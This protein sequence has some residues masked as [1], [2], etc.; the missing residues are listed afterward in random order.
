MARD[1]KNAQ[2]FKTAATPGGF[3]ADGKPQIV[4]SGR[5]NVGKSSVINRLVKRK[6]LA[7]SGSSPGKTTNVNYYLIDDRAYFV[8]LPGYGYARAPGFER[9]RWGALM[10]E[11]F[12][13][14]ER[15][16][17]GVMLVDMRHSPTADD[18]TM[19]EWF[20]RSGRPFVVVANKSDKLKPAQYD[21]RL[22]DIRGVLEL[23]SDTRVMPFSA[24]SG[25]GRDA[26]IG[27][28]GEYVRWG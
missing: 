25:N 12:T 2:Y 15:I 3:V 13:R 19:A 6:N 8:D 14:G 23:E 7:R 16:T 1:I 10:E 9:R 17:L 28:I 22:S 26:L 4:F 27:V 18:R 20:K 5:S 21:G 11:F 24:E